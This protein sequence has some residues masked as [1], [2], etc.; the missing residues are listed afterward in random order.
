MDVGFLSHNCGGVKS[1]LEAQQLRQITEISSQRD[2]DVSL[3][4]GCLERKQEVAF[5][6][7][8]RWGNYLEFSR[9]GYP[10]TGFLDWIV[11]FL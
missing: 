1:C 3:G 11:T 6:G 7:R 8:V 9:W 2:A 4:S 5:Q 10:S